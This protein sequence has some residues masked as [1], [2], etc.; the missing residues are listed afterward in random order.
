[1]SGEAVQNNSRCAKLKEWELKVQQEWAAMKLF[2]VDAPAPG[3]DEY[4]KKDKVRLGR[5]PAGDNRAAWEEPPFEDAA[6][7]QGGARAAAMPMR[8]V[9]LPQRL[10][11]T[12]SGG[13]SPLSVDGHVPLVDLVE[14]L[15][16][17][18][19]TCIPTYRA[20]QAR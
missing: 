16:D 13:L 15:V 19:H 9:F 3:S 2:E 6:A 8:C 7:L 14:P 5:K 1:M 18:A 10:T 17:H 20:P 12:P 11:G 4:L